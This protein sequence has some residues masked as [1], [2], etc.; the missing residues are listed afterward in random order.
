MIGVYQANKILS[1]PSNKKTKVAKNNRMKSQELHPIVRKRR[2]VYLCWMTLF[3][4]WFVIELFIQQSR[5]WNQEEKLAKQQQELIVARTENKQLQK[6]VK[7]LKSPDYLLELAHKLGYS[8]PEEE[9]YQI[10]R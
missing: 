6:D 7:L 10:R 9:N 8:K 3:L 5:I 2:I 4:F 1:L